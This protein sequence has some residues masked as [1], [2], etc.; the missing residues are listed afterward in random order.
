[1]QDGVMWLCGPAMDHAPI[2][3]I[4][5]HLST[6]LCD[7]PVGDDKTCDS[8]LCEQHSLSRSGDLDYCPEHE[9]DFKNYSWADLF[10]LQSCEQD[11]SGI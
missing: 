8:A 4:C 9:K 10:Y 1:M 11:G 7:F 2:C 6:K 5:G 3:R